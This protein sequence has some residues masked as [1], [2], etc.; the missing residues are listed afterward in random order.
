MTRIILADDHTIL[1]DGIR[2]L[3]SAE[4]DLA[5]VGEASNGAE[6]LAILETTPADVVLMDV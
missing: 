4:A 6:V 1:R 5:V 3:L 2:A